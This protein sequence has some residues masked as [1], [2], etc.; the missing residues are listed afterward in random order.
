LMATRRHEIGDESFS[1]LFW[2][3]GEAFQAPLENRPPPMTITTTIPALDKHINF[4]VGTVSVI[5]ARP[6][7]GKTS[8]SNQLVAN[9]AE[10]GFKPHVFS[11]EDTN[12]M[13]AFRVLSMR[14]GIP[15]RRIRTLY[16]YGPHNSRD[17]GDIAILTEHSMA[18]T[19]WE[20][21]TDQRSD[22]SVETLRMRARDKVSKG[23]K[24][25]FIDHGLLIKRPRHTRE[26]RDQVSYIIGQLCAMA[27]EL[28]V[29]VI[30]LTQLNRDAA[31]PDRWP[32]MRDL[33]E[34]GTWEENA[35]VILLLH[36]PRCEGN[37]TPGYVIVEKANHDRAG[38][39]IGMIFEEPRT[40]WR[41][42][43]N[44]VELELIQRLGRPKT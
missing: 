31:N 23:C 15:S 20:G 5:A 11:L 10:N 12:Q 19:A 17:A 28:S 40:L 18:L 16:E 36:R 14:S 7:V 33:K 43:S 13:Q 41:E 34:T 42:A 22:Y 37:A 24:I 25:L 38:V 29:P 2:R 44:P 35:R 3:M 4:V 39:D 6:G 1:E 8:M 21:S 30:V 26:T 27:K 9:Y 32:T